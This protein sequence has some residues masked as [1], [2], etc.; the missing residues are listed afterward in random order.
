MIEDLGSRVASVWADIRPNTKRLI[1]RAL[2]HSANHNAARVVATP[3][4][5][6]YD[7]RSERELSSLLKEL[8]GLRA[9]GTALTAA[10][11]QEL[12]RMASACATVL[13][14]Q[15]QSAEAFAQLL[16]RAIRA[17][18]FA[19]VDLVADTLS[20]KLAPSEL[21]ELTRHANAIVRAIGQDIL[22][23][24][25]TATL[26]NMLNDQVDASAARAALE[27][28]AKEYG[29]DEARWIVAALDRSDA[30]DAEQEEF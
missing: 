22:A 15:A 13:R 23:Q 10:Q 27:R 17:G 7:S 6:P 24:V 12:K 9:S 14:D 18:D 19:Q 16:E 11:T 2:S 21:C 4:P 29:S 28:Q 26:I 30:D 8:D 5:A 1:E 20:T 3:P 25:S